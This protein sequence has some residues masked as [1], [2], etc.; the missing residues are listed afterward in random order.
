MKNRIATGQA[1]AAIVCMALAA[2][3]LKEK[4]N[5]HTNLNGILT[6]HQWTLT[7]LLQ[8]KND[9][10]ND[11]TLL[12][13]PCEKDN[14]LLFNVDG[15]YQI[16]EGLTKCNNEDNNVKGKGTWQYLDQDSTIEERYEGG[17]RIYKKITAISN[18]LM[19]LEY[20][21]EGKKKFRLTYISEQGQQNTTPANIPATSTDVA[22][23]IKQVIR[24]YLLSSN[25]F[26]LVEKNGGA[27]SMKLGEEEKNL[28]TPKVALLPFINKAIP[29]ANANTQEE[30]KA[31][32]LRAASEG[33]DYVVTGKLLEVKSSS[34]TTNKDFL[35][36]VQ[37]EL[38]IL[39]ITDS[40]HHV[41]K[42]NGE[43]KEAA[44]PKPKKNI[45]LKKILSGVQTLS[46]S[47]SGNL[48]NYWALSNFRSYDD[49]NRLIAIN[50]VANKANSA[51]TLFSNVNEVVRKRYYDS[52]TA[53]LTA[54]NETR[55]DLIE[56]L[57]EHVVN[58]IKI[59]RID[60]SGKKAR[61]VIEA[62]HNI[63]L[64]AGEILNVV[65]CT[66]TTVSGKQVKEQRVLGKIKVAEITADVLAYCSFEKDGK[67]EIQE[68]Y[69][70]APAEV[71]VVTTLQKN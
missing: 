51:T 46:S 18:D 23:N 48:W 41:K 15:S 6:A 1:M 26:T 56:F 7:Q 45:F 54:V 65:Q 11:L 20:E 44:P 43:K 2:F 68:A 29:Q 53:V 9:S 50:N 58:R 16:Q 39:E 60:G 22:W 70:K 10:I 49:L 13:M 40:I 52:T 57:S 32:M 59:N 63:N 28:P 34:N 37:F 47:I 31:C 42:F 5:R 64:Q 27:A 61:M 62:G 33:F 30:N 71:I 35:G 36:T 12:L 67:D 38:E 55:D 4:H 19:V 66:N 14:Y 24:Q 3:T 21:G 69:A 25:H 17:S 8:I